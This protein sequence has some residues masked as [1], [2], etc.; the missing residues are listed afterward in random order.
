MMETKSLDFYQHETNCSLKCQSRN[1]IKNRK[2]EAMESMHILDSMVPSAESRSSNGTDHNDEN[3]DYLQRKRSSVIEE[4]VSQTIQSLNNNPLTRLIK[5]AD[6]HHHPHL[7]ADDQLS[8]TTTSGGNST[9]PSVSSPPS[10]HL[11]PNMP[12][13]NASTTN[14]ALAV[15]TAQDPATSQILQH[16][17]EQQMLVHQQSQPQQQLFGNLM[18]AINKSQNPG[19]TNALVQMAMIAMQM[20]QQQGQ[21]TNLGQ[22][23]QTPTLGNIVQQLL[24]A[25]SMGAA[26]N[27]AFAI[28]A[29]QPMPPYFNEA[30]F[31]VGSIR[32]VMDEGEIFKIYQI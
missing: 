15:P 28:P 23:P 12:D 19:D 5:A 27:G 30:M 26:Q 22:P 9:A 1:Y 29:P 4:Y 8:Y 16:L 14:N 32:R 18:Q 2:S 17:L 10:N 24:I 25:Q 31:S 20:N 7:K 6:E 3:G 13:F 11:H 21:Q